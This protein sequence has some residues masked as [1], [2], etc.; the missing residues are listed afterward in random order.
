MLFGF[1]VTG[2]SE[3]I[4]DAVI[5][6]T[7]NVADSEE[8]E[9]MRGGASEGVGEQQLKDIEGFNRGGRLCEKYKVGDLVRIEGQMPHDGESQGLV[10]GFRGPYRVMKVLPND[11][12]M[13]E[14]TPVTR[15]HGRRCEAVVAIDRI[16]PWL[17]FCRNLEDGDESD[18]DSGN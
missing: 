14:D 8:L 18:C 10:V 1:N 4:L 17:A 2:R 15:G 3:G 12:C 9:G 11:R 7:T 5:S 6:D 16:Q 13:V